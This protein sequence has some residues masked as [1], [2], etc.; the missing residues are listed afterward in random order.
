MAEKQTI[1]ER[2][3][4]FCRPIRA[5]Y[6]GLTRRERRELPLQNLGGIQVDAL[7]PDKCPHCGGADKWELEGIRI[8]ESGASLEL[9]RHQPCGN[10]TTK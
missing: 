4:E 1:R 2:F 3:E 5:A 7:Q 9:W 6:E 10:M 8:N